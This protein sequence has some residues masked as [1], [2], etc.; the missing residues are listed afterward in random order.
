M[1]AGPAAP[2]VLPHGMP[3]PAWFLRMRSRGADASSSPL[4]AS[5]GAP[6]STG[7]AAAAGAESAVA[8]AAVSS[9]VAAEATAQ[10]A[11]AAA[12]VRGGD[13]RRGEPVVCDGPSGTRLLPAVSSPPPPP[14]PPLPLPSGVAPT[15][16]QDASAWRGG[17]S[18]VGGAGAGWPVTPFLQPHMQQQAGLCGAA[19]VDG[20]E[21]SPQPAQVLQQQLSQQ[22]SWQQVQAQE[23]ALASHHVSASGR[24]SQQSR[25]PTMDRLRGADAASHRSGDGLLGS[26]V[27]AAATASGAGCGRHVASRQ[28]GDNMD[29]R[30]AGDVGSGRSGA[31]DPHIRDMAGNPIGRDVAGAPIGR[32]MA[33]DPIGRNMAGDPSWPGGDEYEVLP[34]PMPQLEMLMRL[35]SEVLTGDAD[36]F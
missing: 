26:A 20:G 1:T 33:G 3:D 31:G 13:L 34:A 25:R 9:A 16:R 10:L 23:A 6:A 4:R 8:A 12:A 19:R 22:Q 21:A 17:G 5:A 18:A 24:P 7:F 28:L 14:P 36:A 2:A 32:D 15:D 29:E 27:E 30:P 11:A 35:G